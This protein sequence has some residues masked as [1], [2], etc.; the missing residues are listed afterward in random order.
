MHMVY[1]TFIT[2]TKSAGFHSE[3][4]FSFPD[5]GS[6]QSDMQPIYADSIKMFVHH[7]GTNSEKG[8]SEENT[9]KRGNLKSNDVINI[10]LL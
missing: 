6:T 7:S 5:L 8:S 2:A 4:K 10:V 1:I 3:K 9:D